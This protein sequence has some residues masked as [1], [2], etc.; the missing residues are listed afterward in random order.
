MMIT[1]LDIF[2]FDQTIT[3]N[4]TFT[5]QCI[6]AFLEKGIDDFEH[7]YD[8]GKLGA[9]QNIKSDFPTLE[10]SD[11]ARSAIATY[12]NNPHYIAGYISHLLGRNLSFVETITSKNPVTAINIYKVEGTELPFIISY[13]PEIGEKFNDRLDEL[14][15]KNEQ[16]C[17]IQQFFE[18]LL[19]P[20]TVVNFY[21]DSVANYKAA[22]RLENINCHYVAAR[23]IQF[24][25][26]KTQLSKN[27]QSAVPMPQ[28]SAS[29]STFWNSKPKD[30]AV[31]EQKNEHFIALPN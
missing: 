20:E 9:Q 22:Q 18:R 17:F 2:D 26:L 12:H 8:A 31:D 24:T 25:V 5:T 21:D 6:E 1:K 7:L 16:I 28:S 13:I 19:A 27:L 3:K 15:G 11:K 23:G 4:H 30:P 14:T 10:H 29:P